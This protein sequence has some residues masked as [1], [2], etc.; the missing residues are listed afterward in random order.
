MAAVRN[1][2]WPER[3]SS[4]SV[5]CE[6]RNDIANKTIVVLSRRQAIHF[7]GGGDGSRWVPLVHRRRDRRDIRTELGPHIIALMAREAAARE[8]AAHLRSRDAVGE[9]G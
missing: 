7:F 3:E 1:D 8:A 9:V 6:K 2:P 5:E 4:S